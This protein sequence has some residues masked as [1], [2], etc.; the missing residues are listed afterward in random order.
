MADNMLPR[1]INATVRDLILPYFSVKPKL[2]YKDITTI[3]ESYHG[4]TVSLS[5]LKK[6]LKEKG[7]NR[8]R[9]ISDVDLKEVLRNEVITSIS[10]VGYRQMTEVISVKYG[11]NISKEHVRKALKDVDPDGVKIRQGQVIRRRIYGSNGP[12]HIYHLD[13]N[14]KLKP[15]GFCIHGCV[16]GF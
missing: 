14:D 4:K 8:K 5:T 13:G 16:D 10:L 11:L 12:G 9:N 2:K 1:R 3:I 15:W 6:I 7:L